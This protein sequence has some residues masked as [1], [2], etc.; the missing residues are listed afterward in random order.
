MTIKDPK[1]MNDRSQRI[2][3]LLKTM[4]H[5]GRL[6]ILC[7]LATAEQAVSDLERKCQICQSQVSQFLKRMQYEGIVESRKE[8]KFVVY[9]IKDQRI[10]ELINSLEKIFCHED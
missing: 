3:A 7:H 4:A 9:K 1:S 6:M 5:P 10:L 8:G 2:A